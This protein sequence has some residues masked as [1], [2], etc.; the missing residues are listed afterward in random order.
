[1]GR[2]FKVFGGIFGRKVEMSGLAQRRNVGGVDIL[3]GGNES[4]LRFF[5]IL[6]S[7]SAFLLPIGK[8]CLLVSSLTTGNCWSVPRLRGALSK[9]SDVRACCGV[10]LVCDLRLTGPAS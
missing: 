7:C 3:V 10:N 5:N 1:M 2:H 8:G 6:R 4:K 9:R